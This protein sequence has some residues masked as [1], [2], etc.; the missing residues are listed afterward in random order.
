M[1]DAAT[2]EVR[3]AQIFVTTMGAS[4]YTYVEATW[5]LQL[6]DWIR[7]HTRLLEFMGGVPELLI[8]DRCAG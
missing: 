7:S 5:S 4:N 3:Q 2:G 1:I 8:G 6:T